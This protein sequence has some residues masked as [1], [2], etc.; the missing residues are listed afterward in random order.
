MSR[1]YLPVPLPT[2][3]DALFGQYVSAEQAPGL[4][5]GLF[6]PEGLVHSAGFG[7]AGFDTS[8]GV[9][10]DTAVAPDADTVFPIASITKCFVAAG[11]L[12]AAERGLADLDAPISTLLPEVAAT[13]GAHGDYPAPSIRQL[14]GMG[15]GLTED[16]SWIDPFIGMPTDSLLAAVAGGLVYSNPP[17]VTFEY[18]NLGY[19]LVGA[20]LA[21]AVGAPLTEWLTENLLAPL[22]LAATRFDSTPLPAGA[23]RAI[24][25]TLD[26]AGAWTPFAP[27]ASDAFAAAGGLQSTVRDLAAWATYLGAPFRQAEAGGPLSAA[28]RRAMQRVHSVYPPAETPPGS[29]VGPFQTATTGYGLGVVVRE[30]PTWGTIVAHSGGLPGFVLYLVWHPDSGHGVVVLTNSHRGN[31]VLLAEDALTRV[32]RSNRAPART[33]RLWPETARLLDAA[34]AL[35]RSWD[36]SAAVEAFAPNV[37]FDRPLEDRRADIERQIA[38]IGPLTPPRADRARPDLV[39]AASPAHVT[40][41]IGAQRGELLCHIHVTP[42]REARIQAL[43]VVARP[44]DVPREARLAQLPAQGGIRAV[45]SPARHGKVLWPRELQV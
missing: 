39:V 2:E 3:L 43:E 36:D 34:E 42:L 10:E 25:F 20:A 18:S 1:E 28:A 33:I 9:A 44:Y 15:G 32:L 16:N 7:T 30:D 19:A 22:D 24:G 5:Y 27:V 40:W 6:G 35:I 11:A 4:V 26:A 8:G 21:R 13:A 12:L 17:G 41:A 29:A 14:L 31:P 37:A 23:R 45:P 38:E